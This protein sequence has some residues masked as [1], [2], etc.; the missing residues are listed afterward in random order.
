MRKGGE[1]RKG[2]DGGEE[3]LPAAKEG[4][5]TETDVEIEAGD[6]RLPLEVKRRSTRL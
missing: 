6:A 2:R 4:E 1:G 3:P 5:E